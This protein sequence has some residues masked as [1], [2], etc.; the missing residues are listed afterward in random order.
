[1]ILEKNNKA[2]P[3]QLH[4]NWIYNVLP[5]NLLQVILWVKSGNFA[6]DFRFLKYLTLWTFF[7]RK[8]MRLLSTICGII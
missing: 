2:A 6:I 5:Q 3:K 1:M 8:T 4:F 7:L